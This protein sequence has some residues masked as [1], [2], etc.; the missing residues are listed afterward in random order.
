MMVS[1]LDMVMVDKELGT[2]QVMLP[3]QVCP[4]PMETLG[5]LL[6]FGKLLFI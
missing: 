3:R 6:S 4:V 5:L 2:A 1:L